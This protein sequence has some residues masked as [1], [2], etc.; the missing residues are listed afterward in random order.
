MVASETI[1]RP[2]ANGSSSTASTKDEAESHI[3]PSS[4]DPILDPFDV[5][6]RHRIVAVDPVVKLEK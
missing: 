3:D 2:G 5:P 1:S 6:A 4:P